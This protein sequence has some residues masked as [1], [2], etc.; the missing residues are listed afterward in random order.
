MVEENFKIGIELELEQ[1]SLANITKQIEKAVKAATQGALGGTAATGRPNPAGTKPAAGIAAATLRSA[2]DAVRANTKD[3]TKAVTNAASSNEK[4]SKSFEQ[5]ALAVIRSLNKLTTSLEARGTAASGPIRGGVQEN[6]TSKQQGRSNLSKGVVTDTRRRTGGG[7]PARGG[8]AY[9]QTDPIAKAKPKTGVQETDTKSKRKEQVQPSRHPQERFAEQR[10]KEI[11]TS[12]DSLGKVLQTGALKQIPD[13]LKKLGLPGPADVRT[14]EG[15]TAE[16]KTLSGQ[17]KTITGHIRMF[18]KE[19]TE[20]TN[21][22][23]K[24]INDLINTPQFQRRVEIAERTAVRD[25][26]RATSML[27]SELKGIFEALSVVKQG[28][29]AAYEKGG[30]AV[31]ELTFGDNKELVERLNAL[32]DEASQVALLNKELWNM[33]KV[34][35]ELK[36]RAGV[37]VLTSTGLSEEHA[38]KAKI[39]R[40]ENNK[41]IG[42]ELPVQVRNIAGMILGG[43]GAMRPA[44][45][46]QPMQARPMIQGERPNIMGKGEAEAYETGMYRPGMARNLKTAMVDP[47]KVPEVNEDMILLDKKAAESMAMWEPKIT[48]P[49]KE[50]ASNLKEGQELIHGQLLGYDIEGEEITFDMKGAK[51]EIESIEEVV[52]NGISGLRI[53]FKELYEMQTGSKMT[54]TAGFKGV[55]RVE[56]NLAEKYG[57]PEG[58]Q[59]ALTGQGAARR[60]ILSDPMKMMAAEIASLASI[61][62]EIKITGQEVADK[63]VTSMRE[64]GKDLASAVESAANEYGVQGFTGGVVGERVGGL[65]GELPWT[66]LKEPRAPG[67]AEIGDKFFDLPAMQA[68][69]GRAE[70]AGMA[71]DM[72]ANMEK[73]AASQTEFVATL[74]ALA[75]ATNVAAEGLDQLLP[76]DFKRLPAETGPQENYVG[77]LLDEL[78]QQAAAVIRMPT[79]GGEER[80]LRLPAMGGKLGE[81]SGFQTPLGA[82]GVDALTR[83]FDKI[84]EVAKNIRMAEGRIS[85]DITGGGEEAKE[86][87]FAAKERLGILIKE[88]HQLDLTSEEGAT[89][90]DNF[91]NSLLPVIE[92]L[93][94]RLTEVIGFRPINKTGKVSETVLATGK[95]GTTKG[96]AGASAADFIRD[97]PTAQQRLLRTQDVLAGRGSKKTETFENVRTTGEMFNNLELL[98]GV[99]DTLGITAIKDSDAIEQLYIKLEKLEEGLLGMFAALGLGAASTKKSGE[100]TR[101]PYAAQIGSGTALAHKELTAVQFRTDVDKE[102]LQVKNRLDQLA[103]SGQNVGAALVA[104]EQLSQLQG[105]VTKIPR[106]VVLLNQQDYDNLIDATMKQRNITKEEAE[107]RLA[108]PGLLQRYPTTGGASFLTTRMQVDPSGEIPAGK[109]GV[110]GPMAADPKVLETML[111]P[112]KELEGELYNTIEANQGQGEAAQNARDELES[113]VPVLQKL[114]QLYLAAG[115][116][117]DFDGDKIAWLADTATEAGSGL[118]TFTQKVE[119]GGIS[120]QAMASESLGKVAGGEVGNIREYSELFGQVAK[121]REGKLKQAVLAPETGETAEFEAMAH[122]AGKKS[123]GLL[124]D[125]FNKIQLAV[126]TGSK[127]AGDAF[128][129]GMDYI[130]LNIN[131]S[132]AQKGGEGGTAGPLEFLQDLKSGQLGKIFSKMGTGGKGIYGKLGEENKLR[133]G[134]LQEELRG[135]FLREG[136]AGLRGVA[137]EEGIENMMPTGEITYE[138]FRSVIDKMVNELDLEALITRMFQQMKDNM[139]QA[140]KEK[141]MNTSEIQS[142]MNEMFTAGKGGQIPGLDVDTMLTQLQPE[143]MSTR[144]KPVTDIQKGTPLEQ[145]QHVLKLL[146]TRIAQEV[147]SATDEF[148]IDDYVNISQEGKELG[149]K[150]LQMYDLLR[151][152]LGF[153][154]VGRQQGFQELTKGTYT[155]KQLEGFKGLHVPETGPEGEK[156]PGEV[157]MSGEKIIAPL[158]QGLTN[159]ASASPMTAKELGKLVVMLRTFGTTVAHENV[160]KINKNI[161]K[162]LRD[163]VRSLQSTETPLGQSVEGIMKFM[164]KLANI[165]KLRLERGAAIT[166]AEERGV[167]VKKDPRVQKATASLFQQVGE[168]LLA[169]QT[170]PEFISQLQKAGVS[171][172]ATDELENSFKKLMSDPGARGILEAM[173]FGKQAA[174]S[175]VQS[176]A[177]GMSEAGPDVGSVKTDAQKVGDALGGQAATGFQTAMDKMYG[178]QKVVEAGAM[179]LSLPP[180]GPDEGGG[181][182][183]EKPLA[184]I[185]FAKK[186]PII[187]DKMTSI[188]KAAREGFPDIA[189][190]S[191]QES[192]L[193]AAGKALQSGISAQKGTAKGEGRK[194]Y[195]NAMREFNHAVSINYLNKQ[196]NLRRAINKLEDEAGDPT[197]IANLVDQLGQTIIEHEQFLYNSLKIRGAGKGF[198]AES[199]IVTPSGELTPEAL[200]YGIAPTKEMFKADVSAIAGQGQ[201]EQKAFFDQMGVALDM[202]ADEITHGKDLT[203]AWIIL[204]EALEKKP[205]NL[206]VNLKKVAEILARTGGHVGQTTGRLSEAAQ[207]AEQLADKA[208]KARKA[209]EGKDIKTV[210]DVAMAEAGAGRPAREAIAAG[211]GVTG[212][213]VAAQYE[214]AIMAMKEYQQQLKEVIKTEGYKKMGAPKIF[215]PMTKDIIDPKSGKVLQRIRIEAKRTGEQITVSMQQAGAATNNMGNQMRSALRRVVQWGF[216]SGI[217]YGT[218]RAFR[219]MATVIT[220]VQDKMMQLEKVMDTSI[221][222]FEK[223]QDAAVGMAQEYGVSI[224]EVLDGMVVYGQQGLKMNKITERTRATLLAVNVTTLSATEAT[225]ALTAA[226]KVF[227]G[228]VSSSSEFV[229]AWGAVAAKHA[230]TAKDLADAV[231]RSGAAADVAGVGFEDFMGIVTAI[232]SVTRQTGKEI[233]T[234]TKFMFRSMRRPTA[235]KELGKMGIGSLAPTGDFRPAMDILG[236]VAGA[237]EGLTRAQQINTAQ[238]MAGIRHYNSFIVLM[239]NFDEALLAS[240]DAQNSQGF[241]ARKN[242]LAMQTFSKQMQV[243]RETVKKLALELGK[244]ILPA[245]TGIVKVFSGVVNIIGKIPGPILTAS[246]AFVGLGLVAVKTADVIVDSLD[247]ILGYG[248]MGASGMKDQGIFKTLGT[249]FKDIGRGLGR[250]ARKV[251]GTAASTAMVAGEFTETGL[252]AASDSGVESLGKLGKSAEWVGGKF[253]AAG[254]STIAALTGVEAAAASTGGAILISTGYLI[255]IAGAVYKAITAYQKLARTGDD[256]AKEFE[257]QIGQSK[258]YATQLRN[259]LTGMMRVSLQFKKI[260]SA[261]KTIGDADLLRDALN[262]ENF[263]SAARAGQKYSDTLSEVSQAIGGL[264]PERIRGITKSGEYI[265]DMD[266]RLQ[267]LTTS[268]VDAQNAI[269]A[270]FQAKVIQ[271]FSKDLTEAKGVW[272]KFKQGLANSFGMDMDFSLLAQLQDSRDELSAIIAQNEK[273]AASGQI[274]L[275]GQVEL[276]D[277]VRKEADLKT[278]ILET[279]MKIKKTIEDMPKFESLGMAAQMFGPEMAKGVGA[280]APSGVFGQGATTGSV[281]FGY[282]AK[283]AGLG[284]IFDSRAAMSPALLAGAAA[285]RGVRG[286]TGATAAIPAETGDIAIINREIAESILLMAN[287]ASKWGDAVKET[288]IQKA[289]TAAQGL[290]ADVDQSTGK[291]MYRFWDNINETF[292]DIEAS[293]LQD[294]VAA[295]EKKAEESGIKMKFSLVKM[296]RKA[297]EEV[298]EDTQKILSLQYVGAM[299]G[300]RVPTGGMPD[301]G[302][303]RRADLNAEQRS[304]GVE[305]VATYMQRLSDIQQEMNQIT[306]TYSEEVLGDVQGAYEKQA[307]SSQ[308][309]K[310]LTTEMLELTTQLQR[311]G[312]QLAVIGNF[313]KAIEELNITMDQAATATRDARIEEET[314]NKAL[315]GTSGAM[316]GMGPV[317]D[318]DIGQTF[319]QLSSTKKLAL[320]VPGFANFTR[321]M[322]MSGRERET[323]AGQLSEIKKQRANFDIMVKDLREAGLKMT[324]EQR[325]KMVSRKELGVTTDFMET[326]QTIEQGDQVTQALLTKQKDVQ[327]QMRDTLIDILQVELGMDKGAIKE[328][329]EKGKRIGGAQAMLKSVGQVFGPQALSDIMMKSLGISVTTRKMDQGLFREDKTVP[330]FQRSIGEVSA[331]IPKEELTKFNSLVEDYIKIL[332]AA[333]QIEGTP[334]ET[335]TGGA[336][337]EVLKLSTGNEMASTLPELYA[338]QNRVRDEL[339]GMGTV[340][341]EVASII[342]KLITNTQWRQEQSAKNKSAAS[343]READLDRDIVAKKKE[344][345]TRF[346]EAELKVIAGI[347]QSNKELMATEPAR[348]A[349]ATRSFATSL[350]EMIEGFKKAEA[351][352]YTKIDSDLEGPFARVGQPGFKTTFEQRRQELENAP[353]RGMSREQAK[354]RQKDLA[355]LDFD[356]KEAK[357]KQKQDVE[358]KALRTQQS[359]AEQLRTSLADAFFG[360]DLAGTGMEEEVKRLMNTLTDELATSE[361]ATMRGGKLSFRGVGSLQEAKKLRFRTKEIAKDKAQEALKKMNKESITDPINQT[362]EKQLQEAKRTN[363]LLTT[364]SVAGTR[365][366]SVS[367]AMPLKQYLPGIPNTVRQVGESSYGDVNQV[368]RSNYNLQ[369]DIAANKFGD[370]SATGGTNLVNPNRPTPEEKQVQIETRV[371]KPTDTATVGSEGIQ[372]AVETLTGLVGKVIEAL[373]GL[374]GITAEVQEVKTSVDSLKTDG[375]KA[376]VTGTVAVSNIDDIGTA[377]GTAAVAAGGA[378]V[379]DARLR[380]QVLEG[381]VDP[382]SVPIDQQFEGLQT[383]IDAVIQLHRDEL[384]TA[385]TEILEEATDAAAEAA[386]I[387]SEENLTDIDARLILTEENSTAAQT[388]ADNAET[389]ASSANVTA[390]GVKTKVEGLETSINTRKTQIDGRLG[391]LDGN[392][393]R[394]DATNM[395]QDTDIQKAAAKAD[396]ADTKAR[397]AL[398]KVLGK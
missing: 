62:K 301:L 328:K 158:I 343:E 155:E 17:A 137:K 116:N 81:R 65:V 107:S 305:G 298:A 368:G 371:P 257:N 255:L 11:K 144:S 84:L 40:D 15:A 108:R 354:Q 353:T 289:I 2:S 122:I 169:Y 49:L 198:P 147:N 254:R 14:G 21:V 7:V 101:I 294:I 356:E 228:S 50:L 152:S 292:V 358:T 325:E 201:G 367:G 396:Q 385:K 26:G 251:G 82:K 68:L 109:I 57:L 45:S 85:P 382:N 304:M 321:Q 334:S 283:Q 52:E 167:N 9:T 360:G 397:D 118:E 242:A 361:Q 239:N 331:N 269:T 316:I 311:E 95:A 29:A 140:L 93:D 271:A 53:K 97:A 238:A 235:Q 288:D 131:E 24:R 287:N 112:L 379:A 230:I 341:E 387:L 154:V 187:A 113:L 125:Q 56:E 389:L 383:N 179:R 352:T 279:S 374:T 378:D 44:R 234:S 191:Q 364:G 143:Y 333:V 146:G 221:T 163:L 340:G 151:Q 86:A 259:T 327:T 308:A 295:V 199:H 117:L 197:I 203:K 168:E 245:A 36:K 342:D 39:I 324:K 229:D 13:L 314:R 233:A 393:I 237:W 79:R 282:M 380:L 78:K 275:G 226:H 92:A 359:Q 121:G 277:A 390:G 31:L 110:A 351:L 194:A 211:R 128:N 350:D 207:A 61:G 313:Q 345:Y 392:I 220:E 320:E 366:A 286:T 315:I 363:A 231:K 96:V 252:I 244:A 222:N 205:E 347:E 64:G 335:K 19:I 336:Y 150:I 164:G 322:A 348:L 195:L 48:K 166:S 119:R 127:K 210:Q 183:F 281:A 176:Y 204:W 337:A 80:L 18:G 293:A 299:A 240:V 181:I 102:L 186:F 69:G 261:M 196:R 395:K 250:G 178:Q 189:T 272:N 174:N 225:E 373:Q 156:L 182:R 88:L 170:N 180:T 43:R 114:N 265:L 267:S 377:A 256:V 241:A 381:L 365:N 35:E 23:T 129:T 10:V 270:A 280:A 12:L 260:G 216:A 54:T 246:A 27:R 6:L 362:L 126:M 312:F 212:P 291:A 153:K 317:Q 5:A 248:G 51:A 369:Q 32:K 160:H 285:E 310:I 274:V 99:M 115:L 306:K 388:A 135:R 318:L 58:T 130:M 330:Q 208:R 202:A 94:V 346:A 111:K 100:P 375:L 42:A 149:D 309:L 66:R 63:I 223:M 209:F 200:D 67:P 25:P 338:M 398:T 73:V 344:A 297:F 106:D 247:A 172:E 120:F 332:N 185:P 91:V 386:A 188:L 184:E 276:N 190:M 218:I 142:A 394:I 8:A 329:L 162:P 89:A 70:T 41:P 90:A 132:L 284:D 323:G 243:M 296:T 145:A 307:K 87:G 253:T 134:K 76:E 349:L 33:T 46:F 22:I 217:V 59:A 236:D 138:N 20:V 83:R 77:T 75:G 206:V 266:G 278:E 37:E 60:G 193:R 355:K 148:S 133:R 47:R 74:K 171:S 273:R 16:I 159:L 34:L 161:G 268:A 123:I 139:I 219:N 290:V 104:V 71:Q 30:E 105:D 376:E 264:S 372:T 326:I 28:G 214:Q 319:Q 177:E 98:Q 72:Q 391:T 384:D 124:S 141:G 4:T 103:D 175:I 300:V 357:I 38:A 303:A 370:T 263:K 3:F 232:G 227:G 192:E 215:E 339:L 157:F 55:V 302:V 1:S 136:S 258:D 165:K 224:S 249:G 213:S 173:E 262:T